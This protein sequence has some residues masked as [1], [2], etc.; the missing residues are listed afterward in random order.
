MREFTSQKLNC[1]IE[2]TEQKLQKLDLCSVAWEKLYGKRN[3]KLE[4]LRKSTTRLL[5]DY[6]TQHNTL[7]QTEE[8]KIDENNTSKM[9]H[10]LRRL[11][12]ELKMLDEAKE[13]IKGLDVYSITQE[14]EESRMLRN[15]VELRLFEN[16]YSFVAQEHSNL[17][18]HINIHNKAN[19][20]KRKASTELT[21]PELKR[22]IRSC[23]QRLAAKQIEA[24]KY[25]KDFGTNNP[26]I[27][28][29]KSEIQQSLDYYNDQL[30]NRK[31]N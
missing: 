22:T 20:A 30:H 16:L 29:E 19:N 28:K 9:Y 12:K 21:L 27:E 15:P 31:S 13:K 6:I 3:I 25:E 1:A 11:E 5:E 10:A 17:R 2:T 4:E 18:E 23:E 24:S 8:P 14:S 7:L 26:I